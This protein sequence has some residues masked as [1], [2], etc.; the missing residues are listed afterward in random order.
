MATINE[1]SAQLAKINDILIPQVVN[2]RKVVPAYFTREV[3][4]IVGVKTAKSRFLPVSH[5]GY[6]N[7]TYI[8][9][10]ELLGKLRA[11]FIARK[12]KGIE[13]RAHMS[14]FRELVEISNGTEWKTLF[15]QK[16]NNKEIGRAH[17]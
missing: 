16:F 6:S 7:E 13:R 11:E 10:V 2:K 4:T 12:L 3:V 8:D 17:V 14:L 5:E 15:E 1:F 9:K